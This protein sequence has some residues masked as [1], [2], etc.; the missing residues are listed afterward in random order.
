MNTPNKNSTHNKSIKFVVS[1]TCSGILLVGNILVM[2]DL[3][4]VLEKN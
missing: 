3:L 1:V 2:N 4:Q